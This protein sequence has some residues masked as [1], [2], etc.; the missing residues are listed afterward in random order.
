MLEYTSHT[1]VQE[2]YNIATLYIHGYSANS[3]YIS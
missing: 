3:G 2:L 1:V